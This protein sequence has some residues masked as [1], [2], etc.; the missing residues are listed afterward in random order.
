M[1]LLYHRGNYKTSI[2]RI[3]LHFVVEIP[4][5]CKAIILYSQIRRYRIKYEK[6]SH[7]YTKLKFQHNRKYI[8]NNIIGCDLSVLFEFLLV[9]HRASYIWAKTFRCFSNIF[10]MIYLQN[11]FSSLRFHVYN[12]IENF[13]TQVKIIFHQIYFISLDLFYF[14]RF[15]LF[16]F[17]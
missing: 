4:K 13:T 11:L 3:D 15:I 1:E 16:Q 9:C 5:Q 7:F 10:N 8:M 6:I 12:Y 17:P 2:S 14:T